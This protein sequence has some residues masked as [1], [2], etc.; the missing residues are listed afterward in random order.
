MTFSLLLLIIIV[1]I[2]IVISSDINKPHV[3]ETKDHIPEPVVPVVKQKKQK[4]K[5]RSYDEWER[6]KRQR[7]GKSAIKK[8]SGTQRVLLSELLD[9]SSMM[10]GE[11]FSELLDFNLDGIEYVDFPVDAL[12]DLRC[13][14][15]EHQ[16]KN[17]Q[18]QKCA[19]LNNMGIYHEKSNRIED[20]I[21]VYEENI[22]LG[23]PAHHSYKRLMV[24]YRKAKDYENEERVIL[25]ALEV[26][27]DYPEYVDRLYKLNIIMNKY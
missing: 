6:K 22:E 18:L 19:S 21:L 3:N 27:E 5:V 20:A 15:Y 1:I 10:D 2:I 17:L 16:E 25:R 23:Y 4:Q 11:T 14:K 7:A 26:F 12:N 8:A 24:L 13:R 9:L